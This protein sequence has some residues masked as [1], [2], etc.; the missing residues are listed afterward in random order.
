[1]TAYSKACRGKQ[2]SRDA[3]NYAADLDENLSKLQCQIFSGKL[4]VGHYHYFKIYDPKERMICAAPFAER[5][6]HHAVMNVCH[7][8]FDRTLI[9][10]TYATR[11]EK[12]TY[13]A[14]ERGREGCRNFKFV[15]KL[16]VRKY[17]DSVRHQDLKVKLERLFKD[18]KLLS[19]FNQL[20]D[21]YEKTSGRGL[22]IGNLSSQ[23]FANLYLSEID[24][25]AKEL[26]HVPMYIR[27]MDDI[28][29]FGD[30][31]QT[32]RKQVDTVRQWMEQIGLQLKP[33]QFVLTEHGVLFLGYRIYPHKLLLSGRS[34]RRFSRKLR[35]ANNALSNC[36]LS[37]ND[38]LNKVLP[39]YA[40]I[41][42]AYSR[43]YRKRLGIDGRTA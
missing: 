43:Q 25:K 7:Q 38:Y 20:I 37:E 10:D 31:K 35:Q 41:D 33:V 2:C 28:L 4:D 40:F 16:D 6:L 42:K 15:A 13:K 17:F 3:Q 9:Y 30:E 27:Y 8:Y 24:H 5:V 39:L 22:P 26:L 1:M 32:L 36:D 19:V 23:Y 21:S 12:G 18:K 34:K 14:I 11:L 29:L